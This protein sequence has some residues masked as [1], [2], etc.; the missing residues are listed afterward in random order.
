[1][2]FA[3]PI[4]F[5]TPLL[6]TAAPPTIVDKPPTTPG[7]THYV[8]S[9][10]PVR[11][12]PLVALPVTAFRA[13]GWLKTQL[14]LMASGYVGQLPKISRFLQRD[15][16]SWLKPDAS[17]AT[18]WEEVPYWLRGYIDLAYL[19]YDPAMIAEAHFWIEAA[20]R[21]QAPDG[22]FGPN[23]N[24]AANG[25]FDRTV[26]KPDLWAN[27]V[28]TDC[29]ISYYEKTHDPRVI[30]M[31]TKYDKWVAAIP[32]ADLLVPYWQKVRGGDLL[33][34]LV[35]LYDH[36]GDKFLLELADRVHQKTS[37]W[38][39]GIPDDH[40]VNVAEAYR[41]PATYSLLS[42]QPRH[43]A[44][45]Y[46]GYDAMMDKYGQMPGGGVAADERWREGYDDPRNMFESCGMVEMTRSHEIMAR[47]TGDPIWAD[48]CEDVAYNSLPASATADYTGLRYLTAPNMVS[49]DRLDRRPELYN[50]GPMTLMNAYGHRCCQ[51]NTGFGW[52]YF[53][54]SAWAATPDNGLCALLYA[55]LTVTA[56][57]ADG[58]IATVK[59]T[60]D[61]PFRDDVNLTVTTDKPATFPVYFRVPGWCPKLTVAVGDESF[62]FTDKQDKYVKLDR[63]WSGATP[64]KLTFTAPVHVK[65][66]PGQKDNVS[67]YRGPLAFSVRIPE[68]VTKV[69]D[70]LPTNNS[71]FSAAGNKRLPEFPIT[72]I[73]PNGP[74]NYG[75]VLNEND[76]ASSFSVVKKP[77]PANGQPFVWDKVPLELTVKAKRIPNWETNYLTMP[78][79]VQQSPATS[80]EP[81]EVIRLIPM[82]AARIRIS[83]LP[84]IGTGPGAT[85]WVQPRDAE[86]IKLAASH[87]GTDPAIRGVADGI[88]PTNSGD[89]NVPRFTWW[90]HKGTTE[91][92]ERDLDKPTKVSKT[93]VYWFDDTG[94]GECRVPASWRLLYKNGDEWVPVTGVKD[95]GVAKDK[96][97]AVT[98]DPVTT[99]ALRVEVKLRD[100]VSGGVL[101]WEIGSK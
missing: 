55:P 25:D 82:G 96:L 10:A 21:S 11:P 54:K 52:P 36:T 59:V 16:N 60:T 89:H 71:E 62:E 73:T 46:R 40:N 28:M 39:L 37:D 85:A 67:V 6:A 17:D 93:A 22:Y 98:F 29:L 56:K 97:N 2:K 26:G 53:T 61:Y 34:Q 63:A 4:L 45:S 42:G 91:W 8:G 95:Y 50:G 38:S 65:T 20:I 43:I 75:L 51:H 72:E 87:N 58:A 35:W 41:G 78:G 5:L 83:V 30:E 49:S 99:T 94:R 86:P 74:W 70:K 76:P 27:M 9:R 23:R 100:G 79:R 66:W 24:R 84:L 44:Q 88:L 57:V 90:S 81:T 77:I 80:A 13:D 68:V 101:E 92:L 1:M 3:I 7:N 47:I 33:G 18:G 32:P 69:G 31:L 15:N 48:R 19:R 64:V 14:D 12:T